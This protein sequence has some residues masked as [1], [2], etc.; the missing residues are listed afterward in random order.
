M[1]KRSR[2]GVPEERR[3]AELCLPRVARGQIAISRPIPRENRGS[4]RP[5]RRVSLDFRASNVACDVV[6]SLILLIS[7]L[8]A[9]ISMPDNKILSR[10][11]D[12]EFVS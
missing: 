4:P 3:D 1:Y 5:V 10:Y 2:D 12:F 9:K 7:R 11:Y 6:E 8:S